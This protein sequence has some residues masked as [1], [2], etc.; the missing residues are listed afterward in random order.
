LGL[1]DLLPRILGDITIAPA[2]AREVRQPRFGL[3]GIDASQ[4]P[5]V[6]VQNPTNLQ[7]IQ[8]LRRRIDE[9][10]AESLALAIEIHAELVVVHD[11]AARDAAVDLGLRV[12]GTIGLLLRS[13]QAK[14]IP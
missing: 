8:D 5:G 3:N 11:S 12:T 9:G 2:V 10:E 14:H 7:L 13:K 1:Q 6:R 4:L